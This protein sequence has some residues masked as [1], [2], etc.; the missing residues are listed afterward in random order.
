MFAGRRPWSDHEALAAMYETSLGKAPPIPEN[1]KPTISK[2]A[3][4]F[5]S[6][7]FTIS[8]LDRPIASKLLLHLYASCDPTFNWYESCLAKLIKI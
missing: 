1:V 7:C 2:N 8:P 3:L 5:L 6:Q 4:D